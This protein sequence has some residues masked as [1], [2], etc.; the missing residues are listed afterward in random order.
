MIAANA[1]PIID[2]RLR[3]L[4]PDSLVLVSMV[5]PVAAEN[6]VVRAVPAV[7]YDWRWA[8]GLEVC[9]YIDDRC[10][11]VATVKAIAKHRPAY[12]AIW[13]CI[14]RWGA[15]VFL[16]PTPEEVEKPQRL[17]QWQLDFLAWLD[18][19]NDDF[20]ACRTYERD[21]RGM[22]YAVNP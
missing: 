20:V 6:P 16:V 8:H 11:W 19:Q 15:R 5:G 10:D 2:A 17:W 7:A 18:F 9:V 12:L 4:K 14:E 22:P 1:Q 3:G 21:A 13:N